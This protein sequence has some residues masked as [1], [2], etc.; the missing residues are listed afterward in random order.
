MMKKTGS[1]VLRWWLFLVPVMVAGCVTPEKVVWDDWVAA[2]EETAGVD[3]GETLPALVAPSQ[4]TLVLVPGYEVGSGAVV[5]EGFDLSMRNPDF[6]ETHIAEIHVDLGSPHHQLR[7]VWRGPLAG[8]A[9]VGPWRSNPGRG[10]RDV[11]CDDERTSNTVDSY[12]TPK[13]VFAVAGFS[14]HLN[15]AF[16]CHYATWVLHAP[17]YIA[18]HSHGDIAMVPRSE[19]CIRVTADVAKLIHNNALTGTTLIS[20]RGRWV[21]GID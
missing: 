13:G 3:D 8:A 2:R 5:G 1:N 20:I 19:G 17:R 9:P 12:C 16:V 4:E 6:P 11:D 14:D 21:G 18:I 10:K 7:V 15:R